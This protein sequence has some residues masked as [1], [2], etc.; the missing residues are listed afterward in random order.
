MTSYNLA[1]LE[2]S[3]DS[4]VVQE[5][6]RRGVVQ[7]GSVHLSG[8]DMRAITLKFGGRRV[9]LRQWWRGARLMVKGAIGIFKVMMAWD[10]VSARAIRRRVQICL[11][12]PESRPCRKGSAAMC[13]GHFAES[14]KTGA[15]TC[16]C[17]IQAITR[18]ATKRCPL[19]EPKW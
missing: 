9:L 16:G 4:P 19:P 10:P 18:L 1:Q 13:C 5:A 17:R 8:Q 6:L 12:C 14:L 2:Q 15:A 7:G 11:Q 3:K